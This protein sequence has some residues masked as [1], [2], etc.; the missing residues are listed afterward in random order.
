MKKTMADLLIWYGMH[1]RPSNPRRSPAHYGL[2]Y[3]DVRFTSMSDNVELAGWL[4][5]A[6]NARAVV[7][8]C[9]GIDGSALGM[10]SKAIMLHR[11]GFTTLCFDFR[12]NGRSGGEFGTIGY[13]EKDDV[14]GAV[15]FL[16]SNVLTQNLPIF[17]IGES[18]GGAAVIR[19]A[20][21]SDKIKAIVSEATF[22]TLKQAIL[23]RTKIC[24]PFSTRV[25]TNCERISRERYGL[26]IDAVDP[27]KDV[28]T[29]SPRPILFIQ[30][31]FDMLCTRRESERLF[32]AAGEPKE[33]WIV[34]YSPHTFAYTVAPA[35]YER[36]VS[37]FL[38]KAAENQGVGCR[39][40][41][42][43]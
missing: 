4:T 9:H 16:S 22:A 18:M 21:E 35:E 17:A 34:P 8:L 29:I 37:Q 31:A 3:S 36:R 6:E 2:K 38:I 41:G 42:V 24:G 10:L 32:K 33:R 13:R 28:A 26:I 20:A 39:V 40:S 43:G 15:E 25:A 12:A 19:A 30:N 23:N 27:E 7:I 5:P 14:L 11:H 1:K